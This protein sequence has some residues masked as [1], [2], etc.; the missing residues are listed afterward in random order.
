MHDSVERFCNLGVQVEFGQAEFTDEH[1]I[2][3]N[4]KQYSAKFWVIATGSS[5]AIPDTNGLKQTSY[6]T[7]KDIFTLGKLP[8][9]MA[10]LGAGPIAVEMA[11]AFN[12][13]GTK[14]YV[15]QRSSQILSKEDKDVADLAMASLAEEGVEFYLNSKVEN[16]ID[17]GATKKISITDSSGNK[18]KISAEEILVALGRSP[19]IENLGLDHIGVNYTSKGITVDNRMRTNHS[20]IFAPGDI[21][22]SFM[23]THAAGYEGGIVVGNAVFRLPR[24]ADYTYLPWCTYTHPEIASVGMNEKTAQAKGI[25]YNVWTEQFADNDRALAEGEETGKVKMLLNEKEKAIGV[26][27][28]GPHAGDILGEW[29]AILNGK[30]KLATLAGAVHPYPTLAEIN[31]RIAGTYFSGKIFSDTVKKGLK[32]FFSLKGGTGENP[33][34]QI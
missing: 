22:G 20:H 1:T 4:G 16:I 5:P 11:Q 21:N 3:L 19:N 28:I 12:R 29:V 32:L 33:C 23:F 15:I 9:S 31:K 14:V 24:K 8:T 34:S 13:L 30:V 7:N 27:I 26:Q 10:V 2:R 6:L 17:L 25:K 18:T